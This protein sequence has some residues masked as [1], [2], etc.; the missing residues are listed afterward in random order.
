MSDGA[1]KE[2]VRYIYIYIYIRWVLL[3]SGSVRTRPVHQL[4]LIGY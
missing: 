3:V 2:V 1:S 4:T